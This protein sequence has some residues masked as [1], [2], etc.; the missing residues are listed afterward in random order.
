M[1]WSDKDLQNLK[2]KGLKVVDNHL[3]KTGEIDHN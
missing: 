1:A 2:N 3:P